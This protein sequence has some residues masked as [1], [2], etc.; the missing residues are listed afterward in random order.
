MIGI[1]IETPSSDTT[2]QLEKL[3]DN[4][5]EV[6]SGYRACLAL[7]HV[8]TAWRKVRVTFIPKPG[9]PS[10]IE[11]KAYRAICLLLFIENL[12]EIGRQAY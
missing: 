5:E 9:K 11:A 10:Y 3:R 6:L 1:R 4:M 2:Q 7:G 8:P 12:G